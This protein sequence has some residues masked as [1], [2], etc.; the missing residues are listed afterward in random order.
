MVMTGRFWATYT[1]SRRTAETDFPREIAAAETEQNFVNAAGSFSAGADAYNIGDVMSAMNATGRLPVRS[2]RPTVFHTPT[3]GSRPDTI[4]LLSKARR[5]TLAGKRLATSDQIPA[6][7]AATEVAS[8][9][10]DDV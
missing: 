4:L 9:P 5:G 10:H 8:S 3:N 2:Y 1:P 7:L 6:S